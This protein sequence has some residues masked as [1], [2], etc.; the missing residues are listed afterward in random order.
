MHANVGD[1]GCGSMHRQID[2]GCHGSMHAIISKST[3]AWMHAKLRGLSWPNARHHRQA[4]Q[5]VAAGLG[6]LHD[7]NATAL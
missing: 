7:W 4:L 3:T 2:A 1:A 5:P 6:V